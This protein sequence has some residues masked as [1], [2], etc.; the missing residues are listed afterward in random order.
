MGTETDAG[1]G[2]R[3]AQISDRPRMGRPGRRN[4]GEHRISTSATMSNTVYEVQPIEKAAV[5]YNDALLSC[6]WLHFVL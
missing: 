5:T 1:S 3:E 4:R 2:C 6:R